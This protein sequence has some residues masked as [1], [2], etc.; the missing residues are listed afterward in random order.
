MRFRPAFTTLLLLAALVLPESMRAQVA[1][2]DDPCFRKRNDQGLSPI[3][4]TTQWSGPTYSLSRSLMEVK[5]FAEG[6]LLFVELNQTEDPTMPLEQRLTIRRQLKDLKDCLPWLV[7]LASRL[8]EEL[9]KRGVG[10]IELDPADARDRKVKAKALERERLDKE[11]AA[12]FETRRTR[13]RSI[14]K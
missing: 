9:A 12:S 5:Y 11:A 3:L 10:M 13:L 1:S 14:V 2:K 7:A 8:S 6:S 4:T